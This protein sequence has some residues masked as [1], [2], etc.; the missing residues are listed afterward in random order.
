[1]T[2]YAISGLLHSHGD[3]GEGGEFCPPGRS[4][5]KNR[6]GGPLPTGAVSVAYST[7][8]A[9][10]SDGGFD[11]CTAKNRDNNEKQKRAYS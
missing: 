10:K 5:V 2:N 4:T 9:V 11:V 1:M 3:V 7:A 6:G 8:G